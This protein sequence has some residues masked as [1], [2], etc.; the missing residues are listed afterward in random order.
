[1]NLVF[2]LL[3]HVHAF[4]KWCSFFW[5]ASHSLTISGSS[6]SH[7]CDTWRSVCMRARTVS[8][9]L[10][11][12]CWSSLKSKISCSILAGVVI[13]WAGLVIIWAGLVE[14]AL[15]N[16]CFSVGETTPCRVASLS[17]SFLPLVS[18][19]AG[20]LTV[21]NVLLPYFRSYRHFIPRVL[22]SALSAGRAGHLSLG[23]LWQR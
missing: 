9:A 7:I 2:V 22:S 12:F 8:S 1:M 13:I 16:S 3:F 19:S 20:K 21:F 14:L 15:I 5:S 4:V 18:L 10:P 11:F 23:E 6:I 17:A